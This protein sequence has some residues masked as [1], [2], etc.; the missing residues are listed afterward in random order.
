MN[1]TNIFKK[2]DIEIKSN[3]NSLVDSKKWNI[4]HDVFNNQVEKKC[5]QII[6]AKC[7]TT[8]SGS[9][10]LEMCV[11]VLDLK[12]GDEVIIPSFTFIATAQAILNVGAI[13]VLGPTDK[14]TFN[15]DINNLQKYVTKKTKAIIFVHLFGNPSGIKEIS[16]FCKK[17][18]IKLIEDCAQAFGAKYKTKSVGTYGDCA[19]FSFN[20][21][22]HVSSGDGGLF[23]TKSSELFES[24]KA[25]RHA[26]L[27]P[28]KKGIYV[29]KFIGGKNLLTEFQAAI[30]LPQLKYWNELL[31]DR[32]KN[33]KAA[34]NKLSKYNFIKL[35]KTNL[36]YV[37]SYQRIVFLVNNKEQAI[38]LLNKN[39]FLERIYP[40]PLIE[41][42]I[43][44]QLGKFD[45][46][47]EKQA[48]EFWNKHIGFT[49]MPF[50]D[51]SE[52]IKKL[53]IT[54]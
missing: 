40:I 6:G 36:N 13:P 51:Y 26:G 33:G 5:S 37:N 28:N 18:N 22:K 4:Y 54:E 42:P 46:N 2:I 11:K 27:I 39:S 34:I 20:S 50:T 9:S 12:K 30:L 8:N 16:I 49:F 48:I 43:I 15:L 44:K 7:L 41:E 53:K 1:I 38:N 24:A 21:C 29:S 47:T 3:L 52:F 31:L 10:S 45:K 32:I 14:D 23:V 17:N 35:Q 19:A 25:M